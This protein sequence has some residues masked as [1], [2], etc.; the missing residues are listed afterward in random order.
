MNGPGDIGKKRITVS[1]S[2]VRVIVI[3]SKALSL[4]TIQTFLAGAVET[5]LDATQRHT[6]QEKNNI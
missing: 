2:S 5:F 3:V 6:L 1:Y 4:S